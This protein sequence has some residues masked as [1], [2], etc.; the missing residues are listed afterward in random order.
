MMCPMAEELVRAVKS[1][2]E[3]MRQEREWRIA[4]ELTRIAAET[5]KSPD[6]VLKICVEFLERI[7]LPHFW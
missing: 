5:G 3:L 6:E 1:A 4:V 2:V 7:H